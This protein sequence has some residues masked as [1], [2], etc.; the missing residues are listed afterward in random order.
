MNL[1]L[2]K[3]RVSSIGS[4]FPEHWIVACDVQ[5]NSCLFPHLIIDN[6]F[7]AEE[8][9]EIQ[10]HEPPVADK[11]IKILRSKMRK[12][13]E[14][15][16]EIFDSSFLNEINQ[17]YLPPLR[18]ILGIF[19][20]RKKEIYDFTDFH[21]ISTGPDYELADYFTVVMCGMAVMAKVGVT[22]HRLFDTIEHALCV[23]P[24]A[25]DTR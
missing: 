11:E 25:L 16:S 12:T 1:Q 24:D 13:G 14:V 7:D 5:V 23:L 3:E 20:R 15:E 21:L 6:F 8:L 22:Q 2:L 10:Q 19:S 4:S 9:R 17:R 18:D